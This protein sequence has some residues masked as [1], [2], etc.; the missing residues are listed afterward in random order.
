MLTICQSEKAEA[1]PSASHP[2]ADV[3]AQITDRVA[4][5]AIQPTLHLVREQLDRGR[6][7]IPLRWPRGHHAVQPA[8]LDASN[9]IERVFSEDQLG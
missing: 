1:D 4:V 8:P 5:E 9:R 7:D 3:A 2:F 6:A